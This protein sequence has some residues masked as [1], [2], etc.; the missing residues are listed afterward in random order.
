MT[1]V[2]QITPETEGPDDQPMPMP[3]GEA[4][5][6]ARL[7]AWIQATGVPVTRLSVA[8]GYDRTYLRKIAR[9]E[10]ATVRPL[11]LYAL[12]GYLDAQGR[13]PPEGEGEP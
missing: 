13:W 3:E 6:K 7:D 12:R 8:L 5:L 2:N 10:G 1:K 4:A 9:E 11:H